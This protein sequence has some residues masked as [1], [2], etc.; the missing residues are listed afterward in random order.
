LFKYVLSNN[1]VR[2]SFFQA[3]APN[4]EIQSSERLDDHM[5]PL[6]TF[7]LIRDFLHKKEHNTP[8]IKLLSQSDFKVV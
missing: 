3:F 6:E 4:F 2:P 8:H 5:N 7:Q 1:N